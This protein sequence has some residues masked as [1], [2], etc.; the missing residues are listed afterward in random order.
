[1]YGIFT[2]ILDAFGWFFMVSKYTNH[3]DPK[4]VGSYPPI[5]SASPHLKLDQIPLGLPR[6]L[7]GMSAWGR[8]VIPPHLLVEMEA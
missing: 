1:M 8:P 5:L 7:I 6:S 2:R 4:R 3:M